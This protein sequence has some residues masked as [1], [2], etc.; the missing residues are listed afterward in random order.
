MTSR[1]SPKRICVA[2]AG[3]WILIP[4][5]GSAAAAGWPGWTGS[6][7][8]GSPDPPLPFTVEKVYPEIAWRSPIYIASEPGGNHL[9]VIEEHGRLLRVAADLRSTEA[10][11]YAEFPGWLVYGMTFDP[12][13][14]ANRFVYLFR[15][16]P[17][18]GAPRGNQVSR[19]TALL[20]PQP[21]LE[22]A[23]ELPILRWASGGHD[24]GDLAF[25][26]DEM[27][28][29]TT[30]DGSTDSDTLVSGQTLDDLLGSVLRIDV[31]GATADQPYRIPPDNPFLTTPGARGEIW[32][33]GLRNPWRMGIDRVTGQ[34]WVGNNGQ[35]LWE[36]AH[37]ARAGENYG[38]SVFEG[39][40][41]FYPNRKLG[42]TPHVP[43]TIEH[44]H[45]EFRSLT[46]GAV[47]RGE[48]WPELEGAYL[49]GDYATGRIWG[50]RHDGERITWQRELAD[51]PLAIACFRETA[52][53]DVL[54]ADH[55][56]HAL[57][58]L[59]RNTAPAETAPFPGQLSGTGL[60]A[61]LRG[62]DSEP[63]DGVVAYAVNAPAWND[64]AMARR[65]MAVPPGSGAQY[66]HT[67]PWEFPDGTALAQTLGFPGQ[68]PLETRVLLRQQGEWAGYSYRWTADGSDA[69][70][71]PRD[72]LDLEIEDALG[73]KLTWRIPSRTECTVC[74]NRAAHYALGIT[75][76]QLNRPSPS[77]GDQLRELERIGLARGVPA[78]LPE[79]MADPYDPAGSVE[80]RALSYL[81]VNCSICHVESG[82][83][84]A[85]ME[86]RIGTPRERMQLFEARPQ[87]NSF[88]LPNAMLIAPGRPEGSVL[89]HRISKRGSGSGQM[90]PLNTARIDAA[91][92]ALLHEWIAGLPTAQ[93]TWR[94]WKVADF[95]GDLAEIPRGRQFLRGREAFTRTGCGQCHSFAGEGGS[96]GPDLTRISSRL[97]LRALLEAILEPSKE[98]AEGYAAPGTDP[99]LSTMPPGIAGVLSKDEFLDLLYYLHRDG[100]PR[101][102]AVVTEYRHNSHADVIVSRLLQTET[103]DGKGREPRL[104]LVSLYTDQ[105]P[106]T[107][108]SR[109]LAAEHAFSLFPTITETLTL[110][111]GELAVDGILL[112]AEHGDYPY[113]ETGN[114]IYPKRRFWEEI[115][116]VFLT[117]KRVAPVFV[118][119][120]LADNWED[121]RFLYD[122]AAELGA[123]LMAGSSL[124]TTWRR[125]PAD[126]RRDAPL[127][128][129]LA[130]TFHT[131]DAYGFHALEFVQAL[132]EQRRGGETG[133]VAVQSLSG[134]TVW[135][136][137]DEGR[138][139]QELFAA[140]WKRLTDP[141]PQ[142]RLPDLV[143]DPR[144]FVLEYA[145]GLRA[146]LLELNGAAGEWAAAWRYADGAGGEQI[147]STLFWTQEGRPAMH[148]AWL[149]HGVERMMLTGEPSWNPE[150]T[151][152]TSGALDALL[153]SVKESGRR[154][155]T[156]YLN[157]AYQPLWRWQQ[158][159]PPPPMRP[160]SEQ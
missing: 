28:Y 156:P 89:L 73:E 57:Y 103:L 102:A 11:A 70:L 6:R 22:L 20:E 72:G 160:W 142:E 25:G 93:T 31:R 106:A 131:T 17:I 4:G 24:G 51:T 9:I 29:V 109:A 8:T 23:S 136:A 88:G 15:N 120:H 32:A 91:A 63:T 79:P 2:L 114:R 153:R 13:Y 37:L 104:E 105:A 56:G 113:S 155:E 16:G 82:G 86:L 158:P 80:A 39:S 18:E 58:R 138:F 110:G 122:S 19:F 117:S 21:H 12:G 49:Y 100:R 30:G 140:A 107:D 92:V 38:W 159:P 54:A 126:V 87:H 118:D 130:I 75:G 133:I 33:Y 27:L 121:A 1:L 135:R 116:S 65:W 42:P 84:N 111:T 124:P 78:E 74:H 69:Y 68:T 48:K 154:L 35:D 90:P 94:D 97:T 50:A 71:V 61:A 76:I 67:T 157:V 95:E 53:G 64:G 128:E 83:G 66:A 40:H 123:P 47:Y 134:D 145:D 45:S 60:F 132:A 151:L 146:H 77:G 46:G 112:I 7:L 5:A 41:P 119:K 52:A 59:T 149:L 139:D 62:F 147:E 152:L 14:A 150:R 98:I 96:V 44:P 26:P 141:P 36:T 137:L 108:T 34:V 43:P 99:P 129:I 143:K 85:R 10:Q 144:L 101:V 55:I 115:R 127:A 81:H 148:F 125:P 3:L